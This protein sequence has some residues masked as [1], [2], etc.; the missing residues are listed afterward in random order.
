VLLA[1]EPTGNLDTTSS[2]AVMDLFDELHVEGLTLVVIT[3]D[4]SVSARAQRRV[5]I[6][7]GTLTEVA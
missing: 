7:D 5:R 6:A 1:D 3:H 2:A 4:A